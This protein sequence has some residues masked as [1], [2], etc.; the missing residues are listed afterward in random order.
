MRNI[1]EKV[2]LLALQRISTASSINQL[3]LMSA[4]ATNTDEHKELDRNKIV[5]I[6]API[7]YGSIKIT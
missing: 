3:T 7:H 6:V 4:L 2:A 1:M 5:R